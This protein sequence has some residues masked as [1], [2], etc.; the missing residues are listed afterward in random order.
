MWL[1]WKADRKR[2]ETI[3]AVVMAGVQ[4]QLSDNAESDR[5][6]ISLTSEFVGQAV[7]ADFNLP[8][9][10]VAYRSYFQTERGARS[11]E[12]LLL[13]ARAKMR[14]RARS[15]DIAFAVPWANALD[16]TLRHSVQLTDRRLPGGV[17]VG[18]VK[19]YRLS[20]TNGVMLGEFTIGCSIGTG[21]GTMPQAGL[22]S[23]V[24]DGY[25]DDYQA[26]SGI[27][28]P[29]AASDGD[30]AYETLDDFAV[31]DDG[32]DLSNPTADSMINKC[33]VTNGMIDQMKKLRPYQ[34]SKYPQNG[35]PI[36]QTIST[37]VNLDLKPL[38]GTEFQTNFYPAVTP[39]VLP[40]TIDL[41]AP[42]PG[43]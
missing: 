17:A 10:D 14:A 29:L 30:M 39:L 15:V 25:T 20:L 34:R 35:N 12:Y 19:S 22:P 3:S 27:Q 31:L 16:I 28:I 18:K 9:G 36:K 40:M 21:D 26:I 41:S 37:T 6:M 5:E 32:V 38:T 1:D 11:F 8:I 33:Q 4:Q 24:D 42:V 7:D 13:T 2:T 23:Y 43:A